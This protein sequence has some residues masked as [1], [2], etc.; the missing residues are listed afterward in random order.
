MYFGPS[1]WGI[2]LITIVFIM[3]LIGLFS[4]IKN[5]TDQ[6]TKE[7]PECSKCGEELLNPHWEFCPSCG[8]PTEEINTK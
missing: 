2:F 5:K 3:I 4:L 6:N 1:L 7:I 8:E